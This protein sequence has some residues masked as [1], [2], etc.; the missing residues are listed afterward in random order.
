MKR[1]KKEILGILAIALLICSCQNMDKK[2]KDT[3]NKTGEVVGKS[4]T[5]FIQ[6]V[7]EGVDKT[8]KC[9]ISLSQELKDKGLEMGKYE[10]TSDSSGGKNNV[11]VLYIIFSKDFNGNISAKVFDNE[12][13][14]CGRTTVRA[15]SKAGNARY[16]DFTFDKRTRIEKKSR[17]TLE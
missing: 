7:T 17:I 16:F 12:G 9:D 8:L 6:G 1:V 4:A 11:L 13:A 3:I 14:E 5:E 15:E 10:I 2:T